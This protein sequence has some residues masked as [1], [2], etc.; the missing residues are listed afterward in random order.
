VSDGE[1]LF[2][3]TAGEPEAI[4]VNVKGSEQYE[5]LRFLFGGGNLKRDFAASQATPWTARLCA[6]KLVPLVA[7][8]SYQYLVLTLDSA[9]FEVTEAL[10]VDPAG[11]E[12]RVS[13]SDVSDKPVPPESYRFVPPPGVKVRDLRAGAPPATRP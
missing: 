2:V 10:L 7:Q 1:D 8:S 11:N 6:I 12:S 4:K 3:Y 13:F 9:S 5:S